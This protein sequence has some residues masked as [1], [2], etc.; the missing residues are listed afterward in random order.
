MGIKEEKYKNAVLY[1]IKKCN[2]SFLGA[3]KLNKL[4]YYLDFLSYRDRKKSV[5]NDVYCSKQYGPVPKSIDFIKKY[6]EKQNSIEIKKKKEREEYISKKDSDLGVFD[7][8]EKRLLMKICNEFLDYDTNKIVAQT[9]LEGPW[10][11][12]K[13]GSEITYDYASSI[14]VL[15]N[16]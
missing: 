13:N 7:D 3:T 15:E 2:N 5:T 6:L 9:H 4:V 11:Y 10:F 1:F 16:V 14:E 12:S 8:Y